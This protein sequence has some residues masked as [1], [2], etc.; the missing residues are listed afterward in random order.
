MALLQREWLWVRDIDREGWQ[1]RP[2]L[3]DQLRLYQTNY[4]NMQYRGVGCC[5][6][7]V[8]VNRMSGRSTKSPMSLI[9]RKLLIRILF[10]PDSCS[11]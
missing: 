5:T 4:Q 3:L 7:K 11:P 1:C 8:M 6:R 2:C 9:D 10:V